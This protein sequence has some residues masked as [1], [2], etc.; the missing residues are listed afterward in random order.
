MQNNTL[1]TL[2]DYIK[3]LTGLNNASDA[4]IIRAINFAADEY[5]RIQQEVGGKRDYSA[6]SN[7]SRETTTTSNSKVSLDTD[8]ISVEHVDI[9]VDGK[10]QTLVPIKSRDYEQPLDTV[11]NTP[12]R[13]EHYEYYNHH[14]YLYPAPDTS[15][16]LRLTYLRAHPRF[17]TDNLTVSTSIIPIDDE[18]LANGAITRL[19]IGSND[20]SMV[21]IRDA[22]ERMKADI[23]T[24]IGK[25]D[26][27]TAVRLKPKINSAFTRKSR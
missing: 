26:Q 18:F 11:F 3:D 5:S 15:Y 27:D 23:R 10:Y 19:M 1:Q 9:L 17:S 4:K 16:T 12:A 21:S 8:V 13:P 22:Y 6:Y 7:I 2:I 14:L 20:P 24:T 25:I